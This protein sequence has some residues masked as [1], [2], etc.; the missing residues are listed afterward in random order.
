MTIRDLPV[1]LNSR[2]VPSDAYSFGQDTNE[3]Y[4]ICRSSDGW[5]VYYSEGGMKSGSGNFKDESTACEY[6]LSLIV[7]DS[8]ISIK[9][10]TALSEVKS[11]EGATATDTGSKPS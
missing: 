8:S 1:V 5:H 2:C 11:T 9:I 7:S 3:A 4:C 10:N 6:F